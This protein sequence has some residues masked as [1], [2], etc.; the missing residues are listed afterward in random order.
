M[1][2][3]TLNNGVEM[4]MLGLGVFNIPEDQT[5]AAVEDALAAGYRHIDTAAYYRKEEAV[6][7]AIRASGI[8]RDEIWVSTKLWI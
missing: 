2:T 8:A 5:Q 1:Q 6:G 3:V 7:A 4:P